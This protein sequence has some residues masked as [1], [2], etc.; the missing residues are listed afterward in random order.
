MRFFEELSN[1]ALNDEYFRELLVKLETIS[2]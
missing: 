2:A 1:E